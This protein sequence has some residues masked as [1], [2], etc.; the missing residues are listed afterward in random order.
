[1]WRGVRC[2]CWLSLLL[3]G[4]APAPELKKTGGGA[5]PVARSP[6]EFIG[7]TYD[8]LPASEIE[9]RRQ[10]FAAKLTLRGQVLTATGTPIA[11]AMVS[12]GDS[13]TLSDAEG[14]FTISE[15]RRLNQ[16]ITVDADG[17]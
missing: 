9:A 6:E 12:I 11:G 16:A 4:C 13:Q 5:N 17:Y 7:V 1:M 8:T 3:T 15:L 14:R 10:F 2:V